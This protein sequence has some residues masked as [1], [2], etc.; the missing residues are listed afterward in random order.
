MSCLENNGSYS[1][2]LNRIK[3][4]KRSGMHSFHRYYGKLIPAIP[5]MFINEFTEP[6]DLIFDPFTGSGTTAV[7]ALRLNRHF[8]GVEINPLSCLISKIKTSKF[9]VELL[10]KYNKGIVDM[11]YKFKSDYVVIES[12]LPSILNR[13]HWFKDFVQR[14][15]VIIEKAINQF[16]DDSTVIS[17]Y[18]DFYLATLSAIIRNV[19]NADNQ[20][21]FP[22]VS[23]RMRRLEEEGNIKIDVI[24]TYERAINKRAKYF[25]IY[26]DIYTSS[27]VLKGDSA[28]IDLSNYYGKV[29]L[30]VT[31]PPYISSVRYVETMKL[32][33]YW[34]KYIKNSE[35]YSLIARDMLG[36]DKLRK[37]DYIDLEYTNFDDINIIISNMA[38]VDRKSAKII[39]EF[40]NKIELTIILMNRLLKLNKHVVIKISD[41]KIKK[42]RIETG[43]LMCMIAEKNGF[44]VR[45]VFIDEINKN[46]RSLLTARN[47]YSDIITHDY[48]LIW[49]KAN[50]LQ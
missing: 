9:Q 10:E 50:E 45:E 20:H 39:G 27:T 40:F 2:L 26:N 33:M 11:I 12:D 16:F 35:E 23:K 43:K 49:E 44:I 22:G 24:P 7:E 19:S 1:E 32:E 36:N 15:L 25:D 31:N 34:M 48:I 21:V 41:S 4:E 29:D 18:K 6:G 37:E 46:S 17:E 30:I 5:N 47:T 28:N 8:L 14:D 3:I 42:N 38:N 13:D